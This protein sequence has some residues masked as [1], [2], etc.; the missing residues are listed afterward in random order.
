MCLFWLL[1]GPPLRHMGF[2]VAVSGLLAAA[3]ESGLWGPGSQ[4]SLPAVDSP[5]PSR[6]LNGGKAVDG[7]W[8]VLFVSLFMYFS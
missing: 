3:A 8:F 5:K 2:L 4:A 6:S 7:E 1:A